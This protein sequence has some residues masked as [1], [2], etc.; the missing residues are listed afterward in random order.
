MNYIVLDFETDDP[1]INEGWGSGWPEKKAIFLCAAAQLNLKALMNSC[2]LTSEGSFSARIYTTTQ[3]LLSELK[4]FVEESYE[5]IVIVAHNAQYEAGILHSYGFDIESVTW[6]DTAILAKLFYNNLHDFSLNSLAKIYLGEEKKDEKLGEIAKELGLV[7]TCKSDPIKI[8]KKNMALIYKRC[9]KTVEDYCQADVDQTHRLFKY[10]MYDEDGV[11]RFSQEVLDFHSDLI[12]SLVLA[13][14]RG[15]RCHIPTAKTLKAEF[16]AEKLS[17]M[18]SIHDLIPGVNIQS[19]VQLATYFDTIGVPYPTTDKGNPS[20]TKEW[21]AETDHPLCQLIVQGKKYEKY[22]RD[23]IDPILEIAPEGVEYVRVYPEIKIYGAAATGRASCSGP[24]LQQIPKRDP[25]GAKVRRIYHP[26]EGQNWYSL[27]FSAQEPRLQVHYAAKI[28]AKDADVLVEAFQMNP[29]HDLHQ[30]VADLAQ[31]TRKE[32][33]TI[34]LGLAYGMGLPKLAS[35]LKLTLTEAKF[36]KRKFDNL[37]PFL[38][39]LDKF[40]K[41]V[42]KER[43]Y[44]MTLN[45]RKL[46]NEQ[47]FERKAL[48]KL[49]QGGAADQTWSALVGL[50]RAKI[51]FLFPVHDSIECSFSN[52]EEALEVK[53]IMETCS[54]LLVPS[55]SEIE[56]GPNWGSLTSS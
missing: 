36:L 24:N 38:S 25:D 17:I 49:V 45:G 28:G 7:K 16:L 5:P 26:E 46:Y 51:K 13:R 12:K 9:P 8:A 34:N 42:I 48:N 4:Y 1:W 43:G 21:L 3:S 19:T 32:A 2:H 30:Q 52:V 50:Y 40:S 55:L 31:I 41:R 20:I 10:F 33:K 22:I 27:D 56:A 23:F 53:R 39:I 54:P 15:V 35:S 18:L 44:L 14:S 11:Q 29:S 47:G 37:A 6:I